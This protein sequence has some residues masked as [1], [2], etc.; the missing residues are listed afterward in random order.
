MT[1]RI[2]VKIRNINLDQ[3]DNHAVKLT[4][5]TGPHNA[6]SGISAPGEGVFNLIRN[7]ASDILTAGWEDKR[8]HIQAMDIDTLQSEYNFFI[9]SDEI[10]KLIETV[11]DQ[12]QPEQVIRNGIELIEFFANMPAY[13]GL[14]EILLKA[15]AIRD[16][17]EVAK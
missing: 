17:D 4:V 7:L 13:E 16:G 11:V 8:R 9:S 15:K 14:R 6:Q 3:N 1:E 5:Y 2:Q 12:E 10:E